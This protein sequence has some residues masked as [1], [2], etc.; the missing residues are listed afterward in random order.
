MVST[1]IV[2]CTWGAQI[3]L[4]REEFGWYAHKYE[5]KLCHDSVLSSVRRY[6]GAMEYFE[7]DTMHA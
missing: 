2:R 7:L 3:F 1:H 4:N 6:L 5:Y